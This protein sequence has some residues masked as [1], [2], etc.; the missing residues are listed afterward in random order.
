MITLIINLQ[1]RDDFEND[2]TGEMQV[3][4]QAALDSAVSALEYDGFS[5]VSAVVSN[6][7]EV[8]N[9]DLSLESDATTET[10]DLV[11]DWV[12]EYDNATSWDRMISFTFKGKEI[13]NV[14]L[15][16]VEH[17]GYDLA[18]LSDEQAAALG[19]L[20][21][22]QASLAELDALSA[23]KQNELYHIKRA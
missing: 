14:K 17:E 1:E 12:D 11:I 4:S 2:D 22:D 8:S 18:D 21:T 19:D 16:L 10:P 20:A 23:G 13:N 15:W 6:D 3:A 5:F 9:E 7:I